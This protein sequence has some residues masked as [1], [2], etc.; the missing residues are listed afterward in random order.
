[1]QFKCMI[2]KKNM[3]ICRVETSHVFLL[4]ICQDPLSRRA[5]PA[6]TPGRFALIL[7][8]PF[9]HINTELMFNVH[10]YNVRI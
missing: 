10:Y 8:T 1:M 5:R 7:L 6:P 2:V 9:M 4:S 3:S